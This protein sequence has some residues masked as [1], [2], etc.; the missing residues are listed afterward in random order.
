MSVSRI[1]TGRKPGSSN[2]KRE[3]PEII[4]PEQRLNIDDMANLSGKSKSY[5]YTNCSLKNCG[6]KHSSLPPLV[7]IGRN[8]VCRATDFF[9]WM[10]SGSAM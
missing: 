4:H 9:D 1:Y 8:V 2:R 7:K 6:L 10:N 5:Y 3:L